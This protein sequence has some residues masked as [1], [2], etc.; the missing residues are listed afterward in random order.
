M[1]CAEAGILGVY[2]GT[3]PQKLGQVAQLLSREVRR[4]CRDGVTAREVERVR[5]FMVASVRMGQDS[6]TSE[7]QRLGHSLLHHGRVI[8]PE[9]SVRNL[10][11]VTPE[12]VTSRARELF[13]EGFWVKA[14]AGRVDERQVVK[15]R[16]MD[17]E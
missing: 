14:L 1:P 10:C 12:A 2:A 16:M 4:L 9:E 13:A 8:E 3:L 17:D 7:A 15:C 5:G 11:E 6:P